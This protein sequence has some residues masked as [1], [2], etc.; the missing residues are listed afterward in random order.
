MR[1]TIFLC[2]QFCMFGFSEPLLTSWF[3]EG[4]STYAELFESAEDE[5]NDCDCNTALENAIITAPDARDPEML[6][7]LKYIAARVL[8]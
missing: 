3:M 5:D 1:W 7:K 2:F 4:S 8:K 6:E